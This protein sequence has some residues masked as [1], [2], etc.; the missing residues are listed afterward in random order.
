MAG[1]GLIL[2]KTCWQMVEVTEGPW[3]D[4]K[5]FV[6]PAV[7]TELSLAEVQEGVAF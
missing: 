6:S 2:H 1:D 3:G 7:R 5:I 4:S